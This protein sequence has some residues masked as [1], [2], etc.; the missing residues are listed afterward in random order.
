M[1]KLSRKETAKINGGITPDQCFY[2]D[3]NGVKRI[4][5]RRLPFQDASGN[6]VY[7]IISCAPCDTAEEM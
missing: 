3:S 7:P 1:R 5:C 4:G 2:T 6:W